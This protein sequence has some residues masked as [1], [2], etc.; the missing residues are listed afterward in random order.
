MAYA[1]YSYATGPIP[2]S[3][4]R[5]IIITALANGRRQ[6]V[7]GLGQPANQ[8]TCLVPGKSSRGG[9]PRNIQYSLKARQPSASLRQLMVLLSSSPGVIRGD[10]FQPGHLEGLHGSTTSNGY[11]KNQT[12][13]A[14]LLVFPT[15]RGQNYAAPITSSAQ[16]AVLAGFGPRLAICGWYSRQWPSDEIQFSN[17]AHSTLRALRLRMG[18]GPWD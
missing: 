8:S 9:R 12:L 10:Q 4:W 3:F 15:V 18:G 14:V 6:W 16:W 7:P 1:Q 11:L 17:V 2:A 13:K 5:I